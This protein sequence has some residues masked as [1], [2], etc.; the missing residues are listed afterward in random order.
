MGANIFNDFIAIQNIPY[1]SLEILMNQPDNLWF[2]NVI[3]DKTETR[4]DIVR[5]S[6]T[7]AVEFLKAKFP[8][9][10]IRT[11]GNGVQYIL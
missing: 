1:R 5:K 7:Q 3:T 10:K 8:G 4:P 2:D 11:H 9:G 6:M